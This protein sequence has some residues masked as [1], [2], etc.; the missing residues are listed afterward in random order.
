MDYSVYKEK[1]IEGRYI[2]ME[3]IGSC[4]SKLSIA[5]IP[6]G[7][8]VNGVVIN[9]FKL[10]AGNKKILMWSQMHGNESTTTKA[11]CD[12]FKFLGSKEPLAHT[13]LK[14]CTLM[15]VPILNPDG[16]TV[17]TRENI[18]KIDLNRDAKN[19]SQPESRA[20][21][22]LFESFEPDFC[23][24]LHDQRTLFSAGKT[25]KPATVSFLSPASNKERHITP[26][27]EVAM[28]LIVAMDSMLQNHIPGQVGRYDDG[29]NDNCVG[30]AFQK[31]GVPTVLFESGHYPGDYN[32][33][34]TREYIFL[35]ILEALKTIAENK[36]DLYKTG[37]YFSIPNNQ[38][39]FFDVLIINPTIVNPEIEIGHAVGIRYKEVLDDHKISFKPEIAEIGPL[40]G[41]YG[42]QTIECVD[43]KDF[44]FTTSQKEILDLLLNFNK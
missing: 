43:N 29:F 31:L 36:I 40:E 12:M 35:S 41:F 11:L 25:N 4:L 3:S 44:G 17:Y 28:K 6:I 20:L 34:K 38:K 14:H 10:G 33:E 39:L 21:R 5:P 13:I 22:E 32:R 18:N 37:D 23:F 16:A 30:D 2:T 27:R 24:N 42:H 26:T 19:L 9:A 15:I 7:D 1:S 8:S